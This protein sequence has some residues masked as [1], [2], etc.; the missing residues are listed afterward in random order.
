VG[1]RE[2]RSIGGQGVTRGNMWER[3]NAERMRVGKGTKGVGVDI[4][5]AG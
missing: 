1:R 5:G 4:R 2:E 3:R